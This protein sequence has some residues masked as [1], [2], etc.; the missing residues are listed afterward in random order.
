MITS[1]SNTFCTKIL[2]PPYSGR[3]ISGKE[4]FSTMK[5]N[6]S[7]A[8]GTAILKISELAIGNLMV[9]LAGCLGYLTGFL[10]AII[11]EPKGQLRDDNKDGAHH[12]HGKSRSL[13][14]T[15]L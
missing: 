5:K 14:M 3:R 4:I 15:H 13:P 12:N 2:K 8:N 11:R 9:L 10:G 7:D 1:L 6:D